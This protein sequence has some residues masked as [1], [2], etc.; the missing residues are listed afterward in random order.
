MADVINNVICND[1]E[2]ACEA[3]SDYIH[4][5]MEQNNNTVWGSGIVAATDRARTFARSCAFK[6]REKFWLPPDWQ[7]AGG[8]HCA[9]PAEEDEGCMDCEGLD[10]GIET[11]FKIGEVKCWGE[12]DCEQVCLGSQNR[13]PL[14]VITSELVGPYFIGQRVKNLLCMNATIAQVVAASK[15]EGIQ[16]LILDECSENP[17]PFDECT[18][19]DAN[20]MTDCKDW[21]G[22]LIHKDIFVKAR[23]RGYVECYCDETGEGFRTTDGVRVIP[24]SGAYADMYMK[25]ANGCYL[26][27][28]FMNGAFE[29][30]EGVLPNEIE[31]DRDPC[32]NNGSGASKVIYRSMYGL[33]L[34]GTTFD[35]DVFDNGTNMFV[36]PA[37][38]KDPAAWQITAPAENFGLGYALNFCE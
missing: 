10:M 26:S 3:R 4:S 21:D 25:D 36:P 18:M 15:D 31:P 7:D 19:I 22:V 23:K 20:C 33:N 27:T 14:D 8:Y 9:V 38:L 30:G 29:Y 2:E 32:A 34:R 16:N 28:F 17:K 6:R 24:V 1:I 37:A 35:C 13:G 11:M 5:C 12:N